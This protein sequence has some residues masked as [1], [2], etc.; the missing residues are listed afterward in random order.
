MS[1]G[2][3]PPPAARR[4]PR[5]RCGRGDRW[6][7]AARR[8]RWGRASPVRPVRAVG[9]RAPGTRWLPATG[10]ATFGVTVGAECPTG[11]SSSPARRRGMRHAESSGNTT[12]PDVD[13]QTNT[14]SD[15]GNEP[16][17]GC[18][19]DTPG[20]FHCARIPPAGSPARGDRRGL[21]HRTRRSRRTAATAAS[22]RLP[23]GRARRPGAPG[24]HRRPSTP[25][26][27]APFGG[28][29]PAP[30]LDRSA[31]HHRAVR[32]AGVRLAAG[33]VGLGRSGVSPRAS[34]GDSRPPALVFPV[35]DAARWS[36]GGT[37]C[38]G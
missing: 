25:G 7:R 12:R 33:P 18:D 37:G 19:P 8:A 5:P 15:G 34:G 28:R 9:Q 24:T 23:A 10:Y 14:V 26:D 17:G 30:F 29:A 22:N 35:A 13:V 20:S 38:D 31:Q 1:S 3:A 27:D 16:R 11:A 4:R 21:T 32:A 2:S 6:P 36:S